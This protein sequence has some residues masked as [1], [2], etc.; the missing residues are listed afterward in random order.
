[1]RYQRLLG[2]VF[3][4][5][6]PLDLLALDFTGY[7]CGSNGNY[8]TNSAYRANI[9]T[10]LSSLSTNIDNDGFYNAST[11]QGPDRVNA[12][13]W[14]R[15][16]VQLNACRQFLQKAGADLVNSCPVQKEAFF[17]NDFCTLRYSNATVYGNLA[18]DPSQYYWNPGNSMSP[19]QFKEDLR[20]LLESLRIRATGGSSTRKVAA[21]NVTGPDFQRIFA[22]VQCT[23][24]LSSE[25]CTRCLVRVISVIPICCSE[26][27]GGSVFA[28]SCSFRFETKS[29]QQEAQGPM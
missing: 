12:I 29:Y 3:L 28:P 1:M 10:T 15:G 16:D 22:L 7:S 4:L 2:L 26:R 6:I 9:K 25:K 24:D 14:C 21:G 11:G 13:A 27:I 17:F 20:A 19:K 5:L 23:P 8:T 18:L